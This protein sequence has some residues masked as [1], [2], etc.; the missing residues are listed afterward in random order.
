MSISFEMSKHFKYM[1]TFIHNFIGVD[2][3]I[4]ASPKAQKAESGASSLFGK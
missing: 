4:W 3:L 1:H 2:V